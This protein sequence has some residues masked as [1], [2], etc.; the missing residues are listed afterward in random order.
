AGL[1]IS[2]TTSLAVSTFLKE[3]SGKAK[4]NEA[5]PKSEIKAGTFD[6]LFQQ[7]TAVG[8]IKALR[9]AWVL[10]NEELADSSSPLSQLYVRDPQYRMIID[11]IKI[12]Y[13]ATQER[14]E[15]I[16]KESSPILP[17]VSNQIRHSVIRELAIGIRNTVGNNINAIRDVLFTAAGDFKSPTATPLTFTEEQKRSVKELLL[18]G[19]IILTFSAGYMSNVFLPGRFKH[20]I[21][22]VGN[23]EARNRIGFTEENVRKLGRLGTEIILKNMQK[24]RLENG[25]EIDAIEAVSEGVILNSMDNLMEDHFNR[26]VVLR[27]RLSN[28]EQIAALADAFS[29]VGSDYDFR[30]DFNDGGQQCCTEIIYRMLNLRGGYKFSLTKR[31]GAFT[32][33]ADDI[34]D[35]YGKEQN[36]PLDFV[37][38]AE[39]GGSNE[40]ETPTLFFGAEGQAR[41]KDFIKKD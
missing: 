16:L 32:L 22:Y 40:K 10:F 7:I 38:F 33:S 30:F 23:H 29:F 20:G 37:L 24:E 15:Y 3:P 26:M 21:A 12:R 28:E 2:Y 14:V 31:A 18:P 4:L 35:Y 9:M 41:F 11:D 8:N 34:V 1:H 25:N 17:E 13:N 5:Y 36:V 6:S 27:P 39:E 19:D